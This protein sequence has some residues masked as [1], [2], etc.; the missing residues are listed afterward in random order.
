LIGVA[1][2]RRDAAAAITAALGAWIFWSQFSNLSTLSWFY[3]RAQYVHDLRG[4]ALPNPD[5]DLNSLPW[6]QASPRLF[7]LQPGRLTLVTNAEPFGYQVFATVDTH[8]ARAADM[9]FEMEIETGGTTIG[10]LQGG[11]WIAT[12]SSQRLGLFSDS[13]STQLGYGRSITVVIAN[14]N[15]AGETRLAVKSFRLYLRK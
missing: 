2:S 15:P 5:Y 12:N 6:Q 1:A 7:D 3:D 11:K 10:L 4:S 9:Q 13:N 8:G 14:N